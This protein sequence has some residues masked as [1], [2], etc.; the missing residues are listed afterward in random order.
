MKYPEL[1]QRA[2]CLNFLLD[3]NKTSGCPIGQVL[4]EFY[5]PIGSFYLPRASGQALVS[6]NGIV[7]HNKRNGKVKATARKHEIRIIWIEQSK[8]LLMIFYIVLFLSISSLLLTP[9]TVY[10][11]LASIELSEMHDCKQQ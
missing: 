9:L 1:R 10:I 11:Y 8:N 7:L 4:P 3:R 2:S 5:L 6:N